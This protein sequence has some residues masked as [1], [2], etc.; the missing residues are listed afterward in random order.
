MGDGQPTRAW[1]FVVAT[2][3]QAIVA[4]AGPGTSQDADLA[5][6]YFH[7]VDKLCRADSGQLW[8]VSLSGPMMLVDPA[9]RDVCQP[10]GR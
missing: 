8:G 2:M 9:T 10:G 7:E 1:A 3:A 4:V 6:R 5:T